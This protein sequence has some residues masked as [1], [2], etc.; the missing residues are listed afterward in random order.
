MRAVFKVCWGEEKEREKA[1]E[2][3]FELLKILEEELK[4]NMF[5]GRENIG[6]VDIVANII[7]F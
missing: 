1:V 3:A 4:E 2:E 6:M 7:S 5:F